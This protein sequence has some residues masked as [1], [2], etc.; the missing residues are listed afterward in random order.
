MRANVHILFAVM[1]A[2]VLIIPMQS[3]GQSQSMQ[4]PVDTLKANEE[5]PKLEI[6]EI[7]IVGKKAIMLPFARK[8]EIFYVNPYVAPPVDSS[9]LE[10]RQQMPLPMGSFY[11]DAERLTPLHVSA[12]G[13]VGSFASGAAHAQVFYKTPDYD[14]Y[15]IG[16]AG[17]TSGYAVNS[18]G[19]MAE[20]EA[21]ISS[22]LVT[23]NDF[24][25]TLR[26]K[27]DA[28]DQD[29]SYGMFGIPNPTIT[30]DRNHLLLD[31][32]I[33]S[34]DRQGTI[35][36][37]DLRGSF[38]TMKDRYPGMDSSV[39]IDIPELKTM[40]ATDIQSVRF[41]A[42][43]NFTSTS[44]DYLR[45]VQSPSD[46]E[47]SS[48]A[49]WQ[50][51]NNWIL[52][53]SGY[54]GYGSGSEG[55]SETLLMPAAALRWDI[56]ANRNFSVW[57]KPTVS[58]DSYDSLEQAIPYLNRELPLQPDRSPVNIGASFWY[59]EGPLDFELTGSFR[60]SSDM[61]VVTAEQPGRLDFVYLEVNELTIGIDGSFI[62][63]PTLRLNYTGRIL[64]ANAQNSNSQLP[65][66]PAVSALCRGEYDLPGAP[67][68]LVS[69]VEYQSQRNIDLQGVNSL[70]A[71][72]LFGVGAST[73]V[74]EH[75]ALSF[76][77]RNFL[78][79]AYSLWS[80]YAGPGRQFVLTAKVNFL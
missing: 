28:S 1:F 66:I 23:D 57:W 71:V 67:V 75:V 7:T 21:G 27:L 78:N 12:D 79:S 44:L 50:V 47:F 68:T 24:L 58:F 25:K 6:P 17:R 14:I 36:D 22:L 56:D 43:V 26:L 30:R 40:F 32:G 80:G 31:A 59:G 74:A 70:N 62:P 9:I 29:E 16:G 51:F 73:A 49:R 11:R 48:G 52:E 20:A 55:E 53:T 72:F 39:S 41:F 54:Y 3:F 10:P 34:V 15:G 8:G 46:V 77:I 65:N 76:D 5:M 60:Q 38:W 2:I 37:M 45:S 18:S 13:S 63:L 4:P 69:T 33:G 42:D 35:F 64:Q 19:T 61:G